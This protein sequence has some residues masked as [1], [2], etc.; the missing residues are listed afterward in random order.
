MLAFVEDTRRFA[1]TEYASALMKGSQVNSAEKTDIAKK[2][3]RYTGLSEDYLLKANLRVKLFQFMEELQRARGL[4]TGRLDARYSGF[5]YN[6]LA[7]NA[8]Y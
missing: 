8:Q 5:T 4:T 7:E 3:S 1:K 6:L 2:L